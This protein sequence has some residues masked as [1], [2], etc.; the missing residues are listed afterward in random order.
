MYS[1]GKI[2]QFNVG[3]YQVKIVMVGVGLVELIYYGCY[4]VILYKLEEIFMVYL[5]KVLIFWFNCVINGCYFYNGKV[6]QFVVNDLVLQ[7][8]IY[9]LLV[10]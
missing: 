5:G 4:V 2:I 7:I 10:W 9:G 8:V 1:G 6:F 3:Y